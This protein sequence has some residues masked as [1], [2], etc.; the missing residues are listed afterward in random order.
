MINITAFHKQEGLENTPFNGP[1]VKGMEKDALLNPF[2][3]W[4]PEV[5]VLLQVRLLLSSDGYYDIK[6]FLSLPVCRKD[7]P[8]GHPYIEA[9]E[10]AHLRTRCSSGRRGGLHS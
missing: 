9:I 4:E 3:Q 10:L 8:V 6:A 7:K 1:W 5:Q 2:S